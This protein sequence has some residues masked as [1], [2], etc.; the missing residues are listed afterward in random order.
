MKSTS[1]MQTINP[2]VVQRKRRHSQL[3]ASGVLQQR[4]AR[5]A[6]AC[7][8]LMIQILEFK[9]LDS[10]HRNANKG[11]K[12]LSADASILIPKRFRGA[13]RSDAGAACLLPRP[14]HAGETKRF[15]VSKRFTGP[16][17]SGTVFSNSD[18]M[19]FLPLKRSG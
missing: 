17:L 6:V 8:Q 13:K 16:V 7:R 19:R 11:P 15:G 14:R 18:S 12:T 5:A 10:Q 2:I 3:M 9:Y 4:R 1:I